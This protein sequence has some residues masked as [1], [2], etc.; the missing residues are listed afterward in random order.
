MRGKIIAV[1]SVVVLVVG[2]LA[3]ALMSVRIGDL[4]ANPDQARADAVR[5]AAAANSQLKLDSLSFERWLDEQSNDAAVR[6]PFLRENALSRS[7][8]ATSQADRIFGQASKTFGTP[9]TVVA[10]VDVE[11]V[12]LGRNGS[13]LMR[14]DKLGAAYPALPATIKRGGTGSEMAVNRARNEQLLISFA[15]VRDAQNKVIGALLLGV[16]LDDSALTR[17]SESTSGRPL[18]VAVSSDTGV[19]VVAKSTSI[20]PLLAAAP[21]QAMKPAVTSVL[22][23]SRPQQL[24]G[25]PAGYEAAGVALGGFGDGTRAAIIAFSP[26]AL[27]DSVASVLWPIIGATL[28]G[29]VMVAIAGFLLGGYFTGPIVELEAGLLAIINGQSDRRF[30]IEHPDFGGLAFTINSLLNELMGVQEDDTDEHGRLSR[31]PGTPEK[32]GEAFAVPVHTSPDLSVQV[33]SEALRSE[34]EAAYYARLFVDYT[35]AKKGIGEATDHIKET[36]FIQKIKGLEAEAL[37]KQGKTVRYKVEVSGNK[38]NL[39]AVPVA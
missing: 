25:A 24:Q 20:T 12:A 4:V 11:G 5:S 10:F 13:T 3:F 34:P 26:V 37:E 17:I 32:M 14:G 36:D 16:P 27:V 39:M 28:L 1:F 15:A 31:A 2:L 18:A 33:E 38:V 19:E 21:G 9:P 7:E 22:G 35:A 6:E 23:G 30:E 8:E 29:L